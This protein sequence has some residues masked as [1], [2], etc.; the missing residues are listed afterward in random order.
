MVN[1]TSW[2]LFFDPEGRVFSTFGLSNASFVTEPYQAHHCSA[3]GQDY[4]SVAGPDRHALSFLNNTITICPFCGSPLH[5]IP[6]DGNYCT[7]LVCTPRAKTTLYLQLMNLFLYTPEHHTTI[8]TLG[9]TP[10]FV[11]L[12]EASSHN[13]NL[14]TLLATL[15]AADLFAL[16]GMTSHYRQNLLPLIEHMSAVEF[17]RMADQGVLHM[18]PSDHHR[19]AWDLLGRIMHVN[20]HYVQ[21]LRK[22]VDSYALS[23]PFGVMALSA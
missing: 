10:T 19:I 12:L 13:Q 4:G 22:Y 2:S 8:E 23:S 21:R 18:T 11:D 1:V 5:Q 16:L 3:I 9:L 6:G 20:A 15:S 17:F 7:N 14:C